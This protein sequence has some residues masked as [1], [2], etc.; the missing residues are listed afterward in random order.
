[1]LQVV[2]DQVRCRYTD[3]LSLVFTVCR[4]YGYG[5]AVGHHPIGLLQVQLLACFIQ[6][7]QFLHLAVSRIIRYLTG[8]STYIRETLL[9]IIVD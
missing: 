8:E 7:H 4:T 9:I 3:A 1:M 5:I 2:L 6:Q